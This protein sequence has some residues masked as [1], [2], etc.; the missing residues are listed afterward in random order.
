MRA[1]AAAAVLAGLLASCGGA[2][3]HGPPPVDTAHV[4]PPPAG[5]LDTP[6]PP[7]D[8]AAR[9]ATIVV[10][11]PGRH[12][13]DWDARRVVTKA[14]PYPDDPLW[15]YIELDG[16]E[17]PEDRS[18]S[19]RSEAGVPFSRGDVVHVRATSVQVGAFTFDASFAVLDARG[20][21]AATFTSRA[22]L[23]G[24]TLELASTE[25]CRVA[26]GH[27]GRRAI[28]EP[29][30][31]LSLATPDGAW[32]VSASCPRVPPAAQTGSDGRPGPVPTDRVPDSI[33]AVIS[34]Q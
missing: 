31:W 15:T 14:E 23:A 1:A 16:A 19:L 7:L 17:A 30:Q 26:V 3:P 18:F 21:R 28:L 13:G 4:S 22:V 20:V 11:A 27:A 10:S 29:D 9:A 6:A 34:R 12:R 33:V 32:A 8:A 2:V 24:W 25:P 5:G